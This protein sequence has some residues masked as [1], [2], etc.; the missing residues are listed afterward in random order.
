MHAGCSK[1]H[2]VVSSIRA[3]NAV[4][5]RAC[6]DCRLQD[7]CKQLTTIQTMVNFL[8]LP[9]D[10][11]ALV[12]CHLSTPERCAGDPTWHRA[13]AR[14]MI[15]ACIRR[16]S[17]QHGVAFV[18]N[19]R[20]HAAVICRRTATLAARPGG[21]VWHSAN[22]MELVKV[23][24]SFEEDLWEVV[25][26]GRDVDAVLRWFRRHAAGFRSVELPPQFVTTEVR[27]SFTC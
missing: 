24:G 13:R 3:Q 25:L 10:L 18:P 20:V 5:L 17:L 16:V 4:F 8:D 9:D 19:R 23:W 27:V 26:R 15:A 14:V 1:P 2:Y 7:T 22:L 6:G 21:R 12:L 11:M